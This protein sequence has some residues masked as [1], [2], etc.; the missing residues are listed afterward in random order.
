MTRNNYT[1]EINVFGLGK[2][3][4]ILASLFTDSGLLVNGYDPN[5]DYFNDIAAGKVL[6]PEPNFSSLLESA[7]KVRVNSLDPAAISRAAVSI[8]IVPTPSGRDGRYS[9]NHVRSAVT[10]ILSNLSTPDEHLIIIKSTVLPG[11]TSSLAAEARKKGFSRVS[12]VYNPEFIALGEVIRNMRNPDMVLIGSES[13]EVGRRVLDLNKRIIE[14]NPSISLLNLEEAELAKV[15]LNS[16]VTMKISFANLIGEAAEMLGSEDSS[17]VLSALGSDSRIGNKYLRPGMG[18]GGPCFPRDNKALSASLKQLGLDDKLFGQV[19]SLNRQVPLKMVENAIAKL[20]SSFGME[21][22]RVLVVGLGYKQGSVET[23]ES[24]P[25]QVALLL[26]Q[27]LPECE[28]DV[29]DPYIGVLPKELADKPFKMT[30]QNE[31]VSYSLIFNALPYLDH[32][33]L[34]NHLAEGGLIYSPW[35][36]T[37]LP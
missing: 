26:H 27:K 36:N 2:I 37:K 12:F 18:F 21:P 19:D 14:N 32:A 15:A 6:S 1:P 20:P 28:Y 16:Y 13:E 5:P 10:Q 9:L 11:D 29:F 4:T 30:G 8:I 22:T 17:K 33:T 25:L 7:K 23:V 24:Q 35:G 31:L 34:E 3:G